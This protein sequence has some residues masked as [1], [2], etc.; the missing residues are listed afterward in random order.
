M[1]NEVTDLG[2]ADRAME[3]FR[4]SQARSVLP[5]GRLIG[6]LMGVPIEARLRWVELRLCNIVSGVLKYEPPGLL[7]TTLFEMGMGS[8]QA[9]RMLNEIGQDF[10]REIAATRLY[11]NPT[12]PE[13]ART[14]VAE[15]V[16]LGGVSQDLSP[17][18]DP[19]GANGE[20]DPLFIEIV[21]NPHEELRSKAFQLFERITT[22]ENQFAQGLLVL[23]KGTPLYQFSEQ[24]NAAAAMGVL[25]QLSDDE[26]LEAGA[27]HLR[28]AYINSREK[29]DGDLAEYSRAMQARKQEL[30]SDP[31]AP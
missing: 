15:T 9:R 8:L 10:G 26:S 14:L 30:L 19:E 6:L 11:E 29:T 12:I 5:R 23:P 20:P 27:R 16:E 24:I 17:E 4:S 7:L 28:D 13:L 22:A 25:V 21:A 31:I 3:S 18:P 1:S 2:L